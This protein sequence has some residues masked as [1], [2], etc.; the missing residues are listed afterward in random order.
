MTKFREEFRAGIE[1][2]AGRASLDSSDAG[3][4]LTGSVNALNFSENGIRFPV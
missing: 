4:M 1:G 2:N 3:A